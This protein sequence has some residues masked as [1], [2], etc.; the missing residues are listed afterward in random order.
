MLSEPDTIARTQKIEGG[1][2][3]STES[4]V[5]PSHKE[6]FRLCHIP[7]TFN[8]LWSVAGTYGEKCCCYIIQYGSSTKP[9]RKMLHDLDIKPQPFYKR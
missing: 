6:F 9:N 8:K 7:A 2:Y 5:L 4:A 1:M 3:I